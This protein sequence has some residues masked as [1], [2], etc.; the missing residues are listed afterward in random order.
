MG[1]IR[2][3][4]KNAREEYGR[5]R[6]VGIPGRGYRAVARDYGMA[7]LLLRRFFNGEH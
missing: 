3:G 4:Y 6:A 7:L 1:R 2:V 5:C